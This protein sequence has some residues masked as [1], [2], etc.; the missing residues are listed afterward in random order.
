MPNA[1]IRWKGQ[2]PANESAAQVFE[3]GASDEVLPE[4]RNIMAQFGLVR[5]LPHQ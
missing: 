3:H 5:H 1:S 4:P 2:I